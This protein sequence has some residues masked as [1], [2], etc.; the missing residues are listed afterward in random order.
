VSTRFTGRS[1]AGFPLVFPLLRTHPLFAGEVACMGGPPIW[2]VFCFL[3]TPTSRSRATAPTGPVSFFP[4]KRKAPLFCGGEQGVGMSDLVI[5]W[6]RL[7]RGLSLR[8]NL[9]FFHSSEALRVVTDFQQSYLSDQISPP[10]SPSL[11]TGGPTKYRYI[12]FPTSTL[13]RREK[14]TF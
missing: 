1:E 5:R 10:P 4:P 6:G 11:P 8:R 7:H 12:F 9:F 2:A 13:S 3:G 14:L